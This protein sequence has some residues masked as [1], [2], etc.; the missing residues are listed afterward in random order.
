MRTSILQCICFCFL[1]A[2]VSCKKEDGNKNK[3]NTDF[4]P[5]MAMNIFQTEEFSLPPYY[6]VKDMA[7]HEYRLDSLLKSPKLILRFSE[8]NCE[9]C[10]ESE[11]RLINQLNLSSHVLGFASYNNLRMLKLAKAKY[12]IQFPLFFLPFGENNIMP[13]AKEELG[14]P[15]LFVMGPEL[16]AQ[17]VMF[18]SLEYPEMSEKYYQEV[19]F[20]MEDSTGVKDKIFDI[21]MIDLGEITKGKTY[22][23]S[24]KYTNKTSGLLV[25]TSVK[26]SCGCTVPRWDK[27]PLAE[28]K[29]SELVVQFTPEMLGYNS[30]TVMVSH[31]RSQYPLRLII[32]ADVK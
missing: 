18:P 19:A 10:I 6:P 12:H 21:G 24:F 9:T 3:V 5:F 20:L 31:N 17:Y 14:K 11:V 2:C 23:A 22:K 1:V 8:Q 28:G 27:K 25:L 15:Y 13:A 32:K 4:I 29:S 16:H 7:G 26:S 30:K